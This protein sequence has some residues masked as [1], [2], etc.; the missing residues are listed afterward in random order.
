M[1]EQNARNAVVLERPFRAAL[2]TDYKPFRSIVL[3]QLLVSG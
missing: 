3:R 1:G 2:L